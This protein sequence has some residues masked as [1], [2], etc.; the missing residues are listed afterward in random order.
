MGFHVHVEVDLLEMVSPVLISTSALRT[1]ITAH[2][3]RIASILLVLSHVPVGL[4]TLVMDKHVS[5]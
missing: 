4:V 1:R 3:M 5:I 2:L